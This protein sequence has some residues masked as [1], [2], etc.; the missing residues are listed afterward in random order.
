MATIYAIW[1][2]FIFFLAFYLL[3]KHVVIGR[4]ITIKSSDF[5]VLQYTKLQSFMPMFKT[6]FTGMHP[7]KEEKRLNLNLPK[8]TSAATGYLGI[9]SIIVASSKSNSKR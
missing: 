1:H 7:L 2:F 6:S 4:S 9:K 8:F 3:A 5:T